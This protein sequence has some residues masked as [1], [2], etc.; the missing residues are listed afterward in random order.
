MRLPDDCKPPSLWLRM[1]STIA[2]ALVEDLRTTREGLAALLSASGFRVTGAFRSIEEAFAP[3]AGGCADVVLLD[4]GLPGA[5]GIEGTRRLREARP[6]LAILILT[7]Y[8]DEEH[9]FDAICAGAYGYLLKDTP[10]ERLLAAIR[11]VVAGGAPMSPEIARK[12]IGSFQRDPLAT[13]KSDALTLRE[14][15]V[16]TLLA[17][18]HSYKTA[19]SRLAL[20]PDTVRFHVRNIYDKLHVHSKSEAV[21]RALRGRLLR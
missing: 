7:V 21:A 13:A 3:L 10:P 1:T 18:G 15:E 14:T 2:V 16:L 11:E 12:V 4:I 20:S 6:E 19:A 5:S 8:A 9:V 17:A